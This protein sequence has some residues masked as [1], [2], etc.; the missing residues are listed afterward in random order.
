MSCFA[1]KAVEI[2]ERTVVEVH[3]P[4]SERKTRGQRRSIADISF[5]GLWKDRDDIGDGVEYV[6]GLQA[7]TG[8]PTPIAD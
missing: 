5:F 3:V 8:M 7:N 2:K 6:N 4:S 1:V